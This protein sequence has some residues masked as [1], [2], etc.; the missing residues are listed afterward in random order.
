MDGFGMAMK[1]TIQGPAPR[2]L[3]STEDPKAVVVEARLV[4]DPSLK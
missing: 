1:E 2:K 4:N 3:L